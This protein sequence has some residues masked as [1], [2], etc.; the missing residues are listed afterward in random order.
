MPSSAIK[1]SENV[2]D[3][4]EPDNEENAKGGLLGLPESDTDLDVR[5]HVNFSSFFQ[6]HLTS[7]TCV[8]VNSA[9]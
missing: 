4:A 5:M 1:L 2:P 6:L 7:N 8:N 3:N 9:F